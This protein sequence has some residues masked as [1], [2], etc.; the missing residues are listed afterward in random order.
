MPKTM[1]KNNILGKPL[2]WLL[3]LIYFASY[4][5]RINF[6]AIIQEVVTQTG[7]EKSAL[8]IILVVLSI[9]Y[10]G[11]QIVNGWLGDKIKPQNLILT[12]LYLA[13]SMNLLFPLVSHSI[14]L[15]T[16]LW[17]IN[18]FAQAMMWP[19][20]VKILVNACDDAMYGYSVI[21]ISW[22]SS[23]GTILVYLGAPLIIALAGWKAVFLASALVGL[24]ALIV[25]SLLKSRI[26][27]SRT[28]SVS[29][30]DPTV[31][32]SKLKL[33][34]AVFFPLACI[35]LAIIFQGMLRDGVT[36]WM[37]SYLAENF[38]MGNSASILLTVSLAIFSIIMFGIV[39]RLYEKFFQNEIACAAV[40]FG[41]AVIASAILFAFFSSGGVLLSVLMMMLI[42]GCMHG[43]NLML[44]THVP[45][46]F[47]H[48]GNISTISGAVNACTYIGSAIF[49]YGVAALAERLGWRMT[50][51][52]WALIAL[53]GTA[54][55]LVAMKPW[56]KF[57]SR[58]KEKQ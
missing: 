21:R 30:P 46:R 23:F 3:T 20:M 16:V 27:S 45:K 15:M 57:Y 22:G 13:T 38:Q 39:G 42:T 5:T 40:I 58:K 7:Y 12:G 35:A 34:H 18:G 19:P 14:P 31:E 53:C 29:V 28:E 36:S 55:C 56:K 17:A 51:G 44:I 6:S 4:V 54:M 52:V 26:G 33:P 41:V 1:K 50:V 48:L 32:K 11:G 49:T 9:T 43:V 24:T 37:P 10:G 2:A 8:S 47:K 25:W